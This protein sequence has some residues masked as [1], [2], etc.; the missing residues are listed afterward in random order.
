MGYMQQSKNVQAAYDRILNV[1]M[2]D[3]SASTVCEDF[4]FSWY[5]VHA[6]GGWA[7]QSIVHLDR[8]NA[9]AILTLLESI[10]RSTWYPESDDMDCLAHQ[11][12]RA[13]R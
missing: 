6:W 13:R 12:T 3:T 7:P 4:L 11:K 9:R 10:H 1:A 5:N 8:E 2:N